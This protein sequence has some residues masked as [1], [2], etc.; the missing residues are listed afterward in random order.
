MSLWARVDAPIVEVVQR[1]RCVAL[2]PLHE[3]LHAQVG[4]KPCDMGVCSTHGACDRQFSHLSP[5]PFLDRRSL[6][7]VMGVEP[8]NDHTS[9]DVGCLW[10]LGDVLGAYHTIIPR[11]A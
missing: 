4:A 9:H 5:F 11:S 1:R 10:P 8:M 6:V 2:L 3:D 7:G